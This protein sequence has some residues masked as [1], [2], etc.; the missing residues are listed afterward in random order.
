MPCCSTATQWRGILFHPECCEP[1]GQ[2]PC[3]CTV[4]RPW[5]SKIKDE[6]PKL[7]ASKHSCQA[8]ISRPEDC[9]ITSAP[10]HIGQQFCT[11][12]YS[13]PQLF[14]SS[15]CLPTI[16]PTWALLLSLTSSLFCLFGVQGLSVRL[17]SIHTTWKCWKNQSSPFL[18]R[19]ASCLRI[20]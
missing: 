9:S 7:E 6:Q 16:I 1:H 19:S 15:L 12:S 10:A 4:T 20:L 11:T 13:F 18:V 2:K 8:G 17:L 3:S 5:G 14:P